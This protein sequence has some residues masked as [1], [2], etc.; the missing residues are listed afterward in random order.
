MYKKYFIGLLTATMVLTSCAKTEW[1]VPETPA[2]EVFGNNDIVESNVISIADFKKKYASA[3]S[4][5]D[6]CLI[7][8]AIMIKGV[9]S[10]NDI[11]GNIYNE[12]VIQD[13][14]GAVM[15][16]IGQNGICGSLPFGTEILVDLCRL[17]AGGYGKMPQIGMP[18]TSAAG[19]TYVSR[20]NKFLWQQH[21][22]ITTIATDDAIAPIEFSTKL[23]LDADA[24]KL[25]RISNVSIKGADGVTVF[26]PSDGDSY[27]N[28]SFNEYGSSVI[29]RT[30]SQCDFANNVMPMGKLNITGIAS[31]YNDTWQILL[32]SIDDVQ[33]AK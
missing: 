9:V 16:C 15:I 30:S 21:Y 31:R 7:D 3:I 18:Y 12:I 2:T 27:T 32:R 1:D 5:G 4:S 17:Y 22:K 8:E 29:L 11:G 28:R 6:T 26:A 14:T 33:L 23:S 10:G 20:M 25:V 24:G 13:N 19:K